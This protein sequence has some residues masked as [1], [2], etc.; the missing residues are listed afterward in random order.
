MKE[1]LCNNM[2]KRALMNSPAL[3]KATIKN[4]CYIELFIFRYMLRLAKHKGNDKT[5]Q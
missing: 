2:K 3:L 4:S 1:F 5:D